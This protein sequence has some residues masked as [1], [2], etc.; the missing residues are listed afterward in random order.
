MQL[1]DLLTL[2]RFMDFFFY[3]CSKQ[4][5]YTVHTPENEHEN[6]ETP[7]PPVCLALHVLV[8]P[9]NLMVFGPNSKVDSKRV[10]HSSKRNS[11]FLNHWK[12]R[13]PITPKVCRICHWLFYVYWRLG[14]F[15]NHIFGGLEMTWTSSD[16]DGDKTALGWTSAWFGEAYDME[17]VSWN[18]R[19]RNLRVESAKEN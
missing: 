14:G 8:Q 13:I 2:S 19:G 3:A 15:E 6:K 18:Q 16:H 12:S 10:Q 1:K 9:Q 5:R 17:C 7:W 11:P 4:Q